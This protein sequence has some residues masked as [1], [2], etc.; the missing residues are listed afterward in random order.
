MVCVKCGRSAKFRQKK[1][2]VVAKKEIA[3]VKAEDSQCDGQCRV[4]RRER[5]FKQQLHCS[6]CICF[7]CYAGAHEVNQLEGAA[8]Q[9]QREAEA[10][11]ATGLPS[12][13]VSSATGPSIGSAPRNCQTY[14]VGA[15]GSRR[16]TMP[17]QPQTVRLR[18][19]KRSDDRFLPFVPLRKQRPTGLHPIHPPRLCGAQATQAVA[20][21]RIFIFIVTVA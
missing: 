7:P 17:D 19:R 13:I 3:E 21:L 14:A 1:A 9:G 16:A 15:T 20:S 2:K 18:S 4:C 8:S 11:K 6:G 10:V 5:C 12:L